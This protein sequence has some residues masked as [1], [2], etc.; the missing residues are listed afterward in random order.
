MFVIQ[1]QIYNLSYNKHH[2]QM[3][4]AGNHHLDGSTPTRGF[5]QTGFDIP[6]FIN[7]HKVLHL[8]KA[9]APLW[10][11][12]PKELQQTCIECPAVAKTISA[13]FSAAPAYNNASHC[14]HY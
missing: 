10:Q 1:S 7:A 9:K 11:M 3:T 4:K 14:G 6:E 12:M 2:T 5:H 8:W 13:G